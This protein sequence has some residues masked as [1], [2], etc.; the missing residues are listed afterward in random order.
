MNQKVAPTIH[1]AG[2]QA[3][4]IAVLPGGGVVDGVDGDLIVLAPAYDINYE[5]V[6]LIVDRTAK[7]IEYIL[8]P[9]I[10]AAKL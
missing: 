9:A 5:E 3:F 10:T 7:A 1:A 8:G 2:L 4:E 6:D